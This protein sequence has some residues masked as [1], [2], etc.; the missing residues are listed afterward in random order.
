[1]QDRDRTEHRSPSDG[2]RTNIVL[3]PGFVGFDALGQLGYYA[4]TSD[5]FHEWLVRPRRASLHYFDN[6]PTASVPE[7]ARRLLHFLAKKWVRGEFGRDDRV[8]LVGHSTGGLDIRKALYELTRAPDANI[9]VDG[10]SAVRQGDILARVE[11]ICFL[12]TPHYG[13]NLADFGCQFADTLR[14]FLKAAG[15]GLRL[16]RES[17]ARVRRMLMRAVPASGSSL[18]L[19]IDDALNESDEIVAT[20]Q[21]TYGE[22]EARA[23][24]ALWLEHMARDFAILNDLR[25]ASAANGTPESPAHFTQEQ[26]A[27]ELR[28][29]RTLGIKT[30]SYATLAPTAS[31]KPSPVVEVLL[32]GLKATAP[33]LNLGSSATSTG[34]KLWMLPPI[35]VPAL[36]AL[37]GAPGMSAAGLLVAIHTNPRLLFELFAAACADPDGPFQRPETFGPQAVAPSFADFVTGQVSSTSALDKAESDGVV[38]TLSMMWP[39]E[40]ERPD[41]HSTVLIKAD[42]GEIIGHYAPREVPAPDR[43]GRRYYAYD[44]FQSGTEF[45]EAEFR[46]V[47]RDVFEFCAA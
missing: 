19:A 16:N 8:A 36:L 28:A 9:V 42:H 43:L 2:V 6:L 21:S 22:R 20:G 34:T 46:R 3:V 13:T 45:G 12:S 24:F 31:D 40:P 26:R 1:M 35:A 33:F 25:S 23:E 47:W 15:F 30:R 38:N 39:Y 10:G 4:G 7:R 18:L 5:V 37:L 44:F 32:R 11:R 14:A 29:Y 27:E 17:V 41:A